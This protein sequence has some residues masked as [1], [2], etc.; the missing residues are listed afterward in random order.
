VEPLIHA[1]RERR[2][3]VRPWKYERS[4]SGG[5]DAQIAESVTQVKQIQSNIVLW[6][7]AHFGEIYSGW[8]HLKVVKTFIESVL[9]YGV[10]ASSSPKYNAMFIQPNMKNEKIAAQKLTSVILREF[11][12]LGGMIDPEAEEKEDLDNLPYVCQKFTVI[13]VK[14]SH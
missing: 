11:P 2:L 7:K 13:G 14:S 6:C 1:A 3:V 12:E 10:P 8:M 9:R 5:I 4:K